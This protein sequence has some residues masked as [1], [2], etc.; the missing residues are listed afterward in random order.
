MTFQKH[1]LANGL[2]LIGERIPGAAG[3][4]IGI[5]VRTGA[6]DEEPEVSGVS[7]FLEHMMFKG[8]ETRSALDISY[9]LGAMGAQAN[10]FTSE[11]N[12]VYY[13]A[14]LPEYFAEAVELLSDMLR[15]TLDP[16]EFSTEKNVILE[17]I[18]LYQDRPTFQLF[19]AST[20]RFFGP[21]PA[22]NSVLGTVESIKAL[23]QDQMKA[24][25]DRQYVPGNM[26]FAAAGDFDWQQFTDLADKHCGAWK[27][28]T[29]ERKRPELVPQNVE[30]EIR[31]ENI[32]RA[33]V[34]LVGP[35]P[36][37]AEE[38][39]YA[40]GVLCGI[41]GDSTGSH[42]F[43]KLVDAGLADAVSI[44]SDD[45]DSAGMVFAYA[46]TAPEKLA[47]VETVL[48]GILNSAGSFTDDELSQ[49]ITKLGTRLVLQGESSMR[50][51]MSI[52]LDWIYRGEYQPLT[53]ELEKIK[54][55][56]RRAI[57]TLLERY[58]FSPTCTVRLVPEQR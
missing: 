38:E 14:V 4:A 21:H 6:R 33:H 5:F 37:A 3:A 32:N 50:R 41:L 43:W 58:S 7:H 56:D 1:T 44:D 27:S 16:T 17:E 42:A 13:M 10:A 29:V 45:M 55:V 18:A 39:R 35:G 26:V 2:Q 40:A 22:G 28:G 20:N 11:E 23:S 47:E 51:L 30:E 12:T 8:T 57:S 19:E 49:M 54:Q 53:G 46:S 36:S 31:K 15:S 25:F 9:Q 52:G 48:R 34:C 24:Y